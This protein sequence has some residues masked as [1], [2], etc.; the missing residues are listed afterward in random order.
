[1]KVI[2][3]KDVKNVAKKDD[4]KEVSNGYALNYLF[5]QK[6]AELA[7]DKKIKQ[8]EK[9]IYNA[10]QKQTKHEK[11]L[12]NLSNKIS[13][14]KITI[15]VKANEEGHLF[16]GITA[17]DL[18]KILKEKHNI[19]I[20]PSKIKLEHHIK[21]LGEHKIAIKLGQKNE[22]FLLLNIIKDTDMKK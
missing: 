12:D 3:L 19:E 16:G 1:M 20:S 18:S 22:S 9:Q 5:P 13:K 6:L 10:K 14:I 8:L 15:S 11:N 2:F 17:Q 4:I 21:T 7:D